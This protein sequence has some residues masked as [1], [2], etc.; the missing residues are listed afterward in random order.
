M[1]WLIIGAAF[2]VLHNSLDKESREFVRALPEG[3]T[4]TIIDWYKDEDGRFR[5][6]GPPPSAFPTVVSD[7]GTGILSA[8][9]TPANIDEVVTKLSIGE[10]ESKAAPNEY[11]GGIKAED[12]T[13][14][15]ELPLLSPTI[16][17]HIEAFSSKKVIE[18]GIKEEKAAAEKAAAAAA[19][20]AAAVIIP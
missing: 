6:V 17:T 12:L 1:D 19:E 4:Y 18:D 9:R 5:Y 10:V 2:I 3:N 15:L 11:C 13:G 20:A 7:D 8:V 14:V 16:K